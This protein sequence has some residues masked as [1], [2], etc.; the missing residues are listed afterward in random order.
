MESSRAKK[1]K[2]WKKNT[3]QKSLISWNLDFEPD[4]LE[5]ES[6]KVVYERAVP[7]FKKEVLPAIKKGKNVIVCAHQSS[8]RA[9][10]KYIEDIS[11]NNIKNFMFPTGKV[12]RC[13]F[14]EGRLVKENAEIALKQK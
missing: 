5:G 7:Y 14:S 10:V 12:V 13:H 4:L 8:L 11:D 9:L 2:K 6:L 3:E 1:R